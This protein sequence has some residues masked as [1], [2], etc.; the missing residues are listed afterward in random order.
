MAQATLWDVTNAYR[1]PL[2]LEEGTEG[3][4][5]SEQARSRGGYSTHQ[6]YRKLTQSAWLLAQTEEDA[7]RFFLPPTIF[8]RLS[9]PNV[10][11]DMERLRRYTE[12]FT[13]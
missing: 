4:L 7:E 13:T 10:W 8:W 6:N 12:T 3:P 1:V 9:N 2:L 5:P 11:D